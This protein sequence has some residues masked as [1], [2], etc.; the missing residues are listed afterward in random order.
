MRIRQG[1]ASS[2]GA[3][4]AAL[5][6][7]SGVPAPGSAQASA[8][9]REGALFLLLPVGAQGVGLGRA[10][11][12]LPGQESA[13]WNPAGLA[14]L[15]GNRAIL[16]RGDQVAGPSTAASVA[17]HRPGVGSAA[18]SWQLLDVG[19]QDLTDEQGQVRG[20]ITVR[21]QQGI[22]SFGGFILPWLSTGVN[23]KVVQFRIACSGECRD[24]SIVATSY[25]VDVGLQGL[26]FEGIPLRLGALLA[27]AGPR[28]QVENA[29]QADPLPTRVRLGVAWDALHWVEGAMAEGGVQLWLLAEGESRV[30]VEG[31]ASR[32]FGAEL[33]AGTRDV[34]SLRG[35]Y[36][37]GSLDRPDGAA[38]G[39]GLRHERLELGIARSL[40]RSGVGLLSEPMHF[41]L[42]FA[43]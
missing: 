11:T 2:R 32:Y 9:A 38:V 39:V 24:Q 37:S 31:G 20:S 17:L 15:D 22:L 21:S 33:R 34:I 13:F 35:G 25:A 36:V 29:A 43:F 16:F 8:T 40:G 42:G 7:L 26:P 27:H 6:V 3:L 14:W 18:V 30:N 10:L 28:L 5:L 41:T 19:D 23:L 1:R 12:A 4:L